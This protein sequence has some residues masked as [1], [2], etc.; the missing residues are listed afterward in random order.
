MTRR[1]QYIRKYGPVEGPEILRLL[2]TN[3][4]N[5]RWKAFYRAKA[6]AAARKVT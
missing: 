4:A 3:A 6:M 1:E 2:A 5:A